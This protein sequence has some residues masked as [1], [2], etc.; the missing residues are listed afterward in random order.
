[1][2]TYRGW[3]W[4]H[5]YQTKQIESDVSL[6]FEF[7]QKNQNLFESYQ[8]DYVVIG[9]NEKRV[10]HANPK[11]FSHLKLIKASKNYQIYSL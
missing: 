11:N 3:L 9:P 8:V 7:P 2:M 6:M 10:W 5:G 4:T 1:L